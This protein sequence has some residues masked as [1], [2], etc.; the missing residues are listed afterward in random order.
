MDHKSN[1]LFNAKAFQ[2][3]NYIHNYGLKVEVCLL[4][5]QT[6]DEKR[7]KVNRLLIVQKVQQK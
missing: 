7:L 4:Q 2:E 1:T 6:L 3:I 5:W